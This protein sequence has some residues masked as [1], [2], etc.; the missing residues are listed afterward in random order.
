MSKKI[1]GP[2]QVDQNQPRS[3]AW[4]RWVLVLAKGLNSL[5]K[6]VHGH[7]CLRK[8]GLVLTKGLNRLAKISHSHI[9]LRK[10]GLSFNKGP[11]Q[12]SQNQPRSYMPEKGGP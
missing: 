10:E 6:I 2:K 3:Y 11:K 4:E 1:K 5:A 7:I 8:E 9:C 12:V